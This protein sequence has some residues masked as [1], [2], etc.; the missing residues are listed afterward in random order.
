MY[1]GP[2]CRRPTKQL[3]ESGFPLDIIPWPKADNLL[4]SYWKHMY[5]GTTPSHA[6]AYVSHVSMVHCLNVVQ[7]TNHLRPD[8]QSTYVRH[9]VRSRVFHMR[10]QSLDQKETEHCEIDITSKR[11]RDMNALS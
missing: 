5:D 8:Y 9:A 2:P 3:G 4:L 7:T 10:A 1:D 6:Y 11:S